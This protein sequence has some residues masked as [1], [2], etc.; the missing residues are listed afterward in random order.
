MTQRQG[1][2]LP[3]PTSA[4]AAVRVHS[5]VDERAA[6]WT[7][8]TRS[9]GAR[10]R[11]VASIAQPPHGAAPDPGSAC[12]R[13]VAGAVFH[14]VICRL[15]LVTPIRGRVR[16]ESG[17]PPGASHLALP[18]VDLVRIRPEYGQTSPRVPLLLRSVQPIAS[19]DRGSPV[20]RCAP[21]RHA[22]ADGGALPRLGATPGAGNR[23]GER[24]TRT[25]IPL[26]ALG[27]ADVRSSLFPLASP[28]AA[29]ALRR[30]R[31]GRRDGRRG[32]GGRR[33]PR[34]SVLAHRPRCG[35]RGLRGCRRKGPRRPLER[36]MS[37][38]L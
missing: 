12:R 33:A 27:S 24:L 2:D 9:C 26:S 30:G 32:C 17:D 6:D 15:S 21:R 13:T 16:R 4:H 1:P 35:G 3:D 7:C 8:V 5:H 31:R 36:P 29:T 28:R 25:H 20:L 37:P 10:R 14:P 38:A 11:A 19:F 22:L 23:Q 34:P 18:A